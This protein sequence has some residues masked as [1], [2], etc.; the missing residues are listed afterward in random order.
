MADSTDFPRLV[1]LACH[2]LRTPLATI[3]GFARTLSRLEGLPGQSPR[4]VEMIEASS[5][6][7]GELLDELGLAARIESGQYD[8]TLVEID[9]AALAQ[10][11]ADRL[12]AE[13]VDVSGA[14]APVDVDLEA[15]R[16]AVS[17][18]TQCALRHGGLDQVQVRA[19][20]TRIEIEPITR[21]AAP[22]VTGEDLR[23]LGAAVAVLALRALGGSVEL[24]G[25]T[26]RLQLPPASGEAVRAA[27]P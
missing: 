16:R 14:G 26:L 4:W 13:R 15:A 19:V 7:L 2:D 23:D 11:A 21:S 27:G 8:P 10:A 3:F 24:E 22:V 18:L 9:T 6:Q 20:G 17:A 1:S 25:E 12:G 5:E